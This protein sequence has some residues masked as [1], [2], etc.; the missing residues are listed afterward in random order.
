LNQTAELK[1][2]KAAV[3][4]FPDLTALSDVELSTLL[5]E[6]EQEE[7]EVSIHR[8]SLHGRI[9]ILRGEQ[10]TRLRERVAAGES[11]VP[12]DDTLAQAIVHMGELPDTP[13]P[14]GDEGIEVMPEVD[15]LSDE[16]LHT[17]IHGLERVEDETSLHRRMLHGKIDILRAE[18]ALRSQRRGEGAG[19]GHVGVGR[20]QDILAANLLWKRP[21]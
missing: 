11:V 15:K 10:T 3:D 2:R 6:L 14:P 18:R 20:L 4:V 8:R 7:E 9:D 12:D 19:P 1:R 16:D 5:L 21:E 17:L 13:L